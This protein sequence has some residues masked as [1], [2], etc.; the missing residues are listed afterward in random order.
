MGPVGRLELGLTMKSKSPLHK[1]R[2]L[3]GM[4]SRDDGGSSSTPADV[5]HLDT[6]VTR[7]D[8]KAIDG[9]YR[10]APAA[11]HVPRQI[12][13]CPGISFFGRRVKS[14]VFSTDLAIICNC[15]A[16]AVFAVYPFTCQPIITQGLVTASGRPVFTG[17]AGTTTAGARSKTMAVQSEMQGAYGVVVNSPTSIEDVREI[18]TSIDIPVVLTVVTF[19]ELVATKIMAGAKVVNVAA[20]KD[21][22][23]VVEKVRERFPE[24]PIIASGGKDAASI[25]STIDAGADAITWVPPTM[26]QLQRELMDVNRAEGQ[27]TEPDAVA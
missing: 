21:T 4:R 5:M 14:L 25:R 22:P 18:S 12:D 16:D 9:T 27:P 11:L 1:I 17:V 20:G 3:K 23:A 19:D 6:I 10:H 7:C 24:I 26:Q 2:A 8:P 13:A 15:D